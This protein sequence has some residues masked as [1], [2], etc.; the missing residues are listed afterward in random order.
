MKTMFSE[1]WS[2]GQYLK[3]HIFLD[4]YAVGKARARKYHLYSH[5]HQNFT[6]NWS[7]LPGSWF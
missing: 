3:K 4:G 6:S 5:I 1:W 7:F 2:I